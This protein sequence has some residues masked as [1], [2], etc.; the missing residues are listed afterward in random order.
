VFVES[1]V[2]IIL[3]LVDLGGQMFTSLLIFDKNSNHAGKHNSRKSGRE[4]RADKYGDISESWMRAC[5][6][7]RQLATISCLPSKHWDKQF[8]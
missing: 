3:S 6:V 5:L 8:L 7:Q 4:D 2:P 1:T